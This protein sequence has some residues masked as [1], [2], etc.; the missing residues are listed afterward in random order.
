MDILKS[1]TKQFEHLINSGKINES[2][3][4]TELRSMGYLAADTTNSS[5]ATILNEFYEEVK[6]SISSDAHP[7]SL[8]GV[9]EH[10]FEIDSLQKLKPHA[11][12][13]QDIIIAC[14]HLS[15]K[16][17]FIRIGWSVGIHQQIRPDVPMPSP[18][19]KAAKKVEEWH[20]PFHASYD[21]KSH[22]LSCLYL[23][24]QLKIFATH[25]IQ[26][27]SPVRQPGFVITQLGAFALTN[28]VNT[29]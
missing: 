26:S 16:L 13:N 29:F 25:A 4:N 22:T 17:S 2:E 27:S 20:N 10:T 24:R 11:C 15:D 7:Q 3:F 18:F 5:N 23:D 9:S 6:Q 8:I 1:L 12:L 19:E 28:N 21:N 14:L